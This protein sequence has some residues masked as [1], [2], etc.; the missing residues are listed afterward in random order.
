MDLNKNGIYGIYI[1]YMQ[2]ETVPMVLFPMGHKLWD[3]NLHHKAKNNIVITDLTQTLYATRN[4]RALGMICPLCGLIYKTIISVSQSQSSQLLNHK[5][6]L[7]KTTQ[8][9]FEKT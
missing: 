8:V 2:R 9:S 3:K 6:F 4:I 1:L 5:L 7:Q